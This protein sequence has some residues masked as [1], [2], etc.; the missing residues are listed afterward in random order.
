MS[1]LHLAEGKRKLSTATVEIENIFTKD[2]HKLKIKTGES[3]HTYLIHGDDLA[4]IADLCNEME[5]NRHRFITD[6]PRDAL[7]ALFGR[8]A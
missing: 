2:E 8:G 3:T 5:R 6:S 4:I 1:I 7:D